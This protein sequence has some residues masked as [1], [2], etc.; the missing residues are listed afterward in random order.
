MIK[1]RILA[2]FLVAVLVTAFIPLSASANS[3]TGFTM[4]MTGDFG[5]IAI[6]LTVTTPFEYFGTVPLSVPL[7]T[8]GVSPTPQMLNLMVVND[9][10]N[11]VI[12]ASHFESSLLS[13]YVLAGELDAQRINEV[14]LAIDDEGLFSWHEFMY[15][16]P[17]SLGFPIGNISSIYKVIDNGFFV[18][19]VPTEFSRRYVLSPLIII[20]QTQRAA[21]LANGIL[22]SGIADFEEYLDISVL[23]T[24]LSGSAVQLPTTPS[25]PPAPPAPPAPPPMPPTPPAP[26]PTTTPPAQNIRVILNGAALNFGVPP[27]VIGGRTMVPLR[28]IFEAL[29]AEVDWNASTQT[30]TGT[31]GSTVVQLTIGS[32]SPTVN[33]VVVPIDQPGVVIEERT[34]VPLRFVGES[35][36]VTVEWDGPTSTITITS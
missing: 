6:H 34:M 19:P 29:G 32:T 8:G 23:R 17:P 20:S 9:N 21:F 3:S 11:V 15:R 26:P 4:R 36:G 5:E 13:G 22:P 12:A 27:Q 10:V 18:D 31:K 2:F 16:S 14:F 28:A 24:A 1:K 25:T 7:P 35:L 33:G 30:V